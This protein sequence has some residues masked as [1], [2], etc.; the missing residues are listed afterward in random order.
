[1][2]VDLGAKT[3]HVF[4]DSEVVVKQMTGEY[5]CRSTQL[6]SLNWTC[7]KLARSLDFSISH[8]TRENNVEANSLA[9]SAARK[10]SRIRTSSARTIVAQNCLTVFQGCFHSV[11]DANS[12]RISFNLC[13]LRWWSTSPGIFL[14]PCTYWRLASLICD[15]SSRNFA[16]RSLTGC[17][18]GTRCK[19]GKARLFP[20]SR[21]DLCPACLSCCSDPC[22][23]GWGNPPLRSSSGGR[24]PCALLF[25][26][27][28]TL[29]GSNAPTC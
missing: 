11:S 21:S 19:S 22:D 23:A 18:M 10:A 20:S 13:S 14:P 17:C 5:T 16:T 1:M 26:P 7:R 12:S 24:S 9:N 27:A 4:S 25:R 29:G 3:L 2:R 6:Y 28:R 8:V 15:I